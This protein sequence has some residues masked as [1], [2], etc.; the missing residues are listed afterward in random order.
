M[1]TVTVENIMLNKL[2]IVCKSSGYNIRYDSNNLTIEFPEL[3]SYGVRIRRN[4]VD[5][6]GSDSNSENK[7]ESKYIV[8]ELNRDVHETFIDKYD[9][10]YYALILLYCK[11]FLKYTKEQINNVY[12]TQELLR[13]PLGIVGKDH[14]Q[15][16]RLYM[17]VTKYTKFFDKDGNQLT[18]DSKLINEDFRAIP[19]VTFSRITAYEKDDKTYYYINYFLN[20]VRLTQDV[21]HIEA[22][23]D[24]EIFNILNQR[25]TEKNQA[26]Q[27]SNVN[28]EEEV[29]NSKPTKTI[30]QPITSNLPKL[31]KPKPP[32]I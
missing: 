3:V 10:L 8:F 25:I 15:R 29:K 31:S 16:I 1:K 12:S 32:P 19:I 24:T 18:D 28:L 14:L 22:K 11:S 4:M 30:S 23:F 6:S 7:T 2:S 17:N 20:E 9:D 21:E 27:V 13:D 5:D 26:N